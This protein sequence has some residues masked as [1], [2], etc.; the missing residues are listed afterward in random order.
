MQREE[1]FS[2]FLCGSLEKA[3][4]CFLASSIFLASSHTALYCV[5]CNTYTPPEGIGS[6]SGRGNLINNHSHFCFELGL[7]LTSLHMVSNLRHMSQNF[8]K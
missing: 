8:I 3:T 7:I 1:H 2:I 5:L 6:S 4:A